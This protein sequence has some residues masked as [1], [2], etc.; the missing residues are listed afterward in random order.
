MATSP[1]EIIVALSDVF[2]LNN[3]RNP[4]LHPG[5]VQ[6]AEA[7]LHEPARLDW[8]WLLVLGVDDDA[9][10][11]DLLVESVVVDDGFDT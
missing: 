8:P 4:E 7:P 11:T 9:S 1:G 6:D 2:G 5:E 10:S 3:H